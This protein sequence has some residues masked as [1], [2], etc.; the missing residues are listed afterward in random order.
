MYVG[1]SFE[2]IAMAGDI[3]TRL[4]WMIFRIFW[5]KMAVLVPSPIYRFGTRSPTCKW[6]PRS[7]I[8]RHGIHILDI[9]E[10]ME[11]NVEWQKQ[12]QVPQAHTAPNSDNGIKFKTEAFHHQMLVISANIIQHC[13][14]PSI[15]WSLQGEDEGPLEIV[16][17][18]KIFHYGQ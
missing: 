11:R 12:L 7:V 10:N 1:I 3:R 6:I 13:I 16:G 18:L 8:T 9:H 2:T 17:N 14:E 4:F 5:R 15:D